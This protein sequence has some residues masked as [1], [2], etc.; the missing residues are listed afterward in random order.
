MTADPPVLRVDFRG[1]GGWT[2]RRGDDEGVTTIRPARAEDLPVLQDLERAAGTPFRALGMD[3]VADDEPLPIEHLAGYQRAGRAWVAE[4]R[5]SV[6]GYLLVDVVAGAAHI[7]QVSVDPTRAHR[8]IGR[9][10]IEAAE[11]WAREHALPAMTLT[12]FEHVPWN[13]PYYARL[14]FTALPEV[15]QPPELAA[16]RRAEAE[17]GLD[18]WPRLAMRRQLEQAPHPPPPHRPHQ[19]P[20]SDAR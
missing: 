9:A 4:E 6:V 19:G 15:E 7:E 20:V 16:L 13:A 5:G 8:G 14:G 11:G 12:S 2:G 1:D 3:A 17:R 10:L 18:V